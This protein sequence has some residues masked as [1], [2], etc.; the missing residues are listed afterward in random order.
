MDR[1]LPAARLVPRDGADRRAIL[2][3]EAADQ[4]RKAGRV[5]VSVTK[6]VALL[7]LCGL[8]IGVLAVGARSSRYQ[9]KD[10][11]PSLER[12]RSIQLDFP[13]HQSPQSLE[14]ERLRHQIDLQMLESEHA[15]MQ[16]RRQLDLGTGLTPEDIHAR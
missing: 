5:A 7:A 1:K 13:K 12:I 8:G 9:T 16:Y 3:A 6:G 14:L 10:L 11:G 2:R 15:R 4:A